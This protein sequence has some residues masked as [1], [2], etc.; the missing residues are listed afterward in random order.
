MDGDEEERK[1][2]GCTSV[3]SACWFV[4]KG[5]RWAGFLQEVGGMS[6]MMDGWM[7]FGGICCVALS[8]VCVC[9]C[10]VCVGILQFISGQ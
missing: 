4:S 8:L 1:E 9:V 7:E 5:E 6:C 2:N 3:P 10:V